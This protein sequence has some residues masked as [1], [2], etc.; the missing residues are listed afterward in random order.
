MER[1][2]EIPGAKKAPIGVPTI[3]FHK[4]DG[5]NLRWEWS[6]KKGW[7]KFG[8][9]TELFDWRH[10]MWGQAIP[11]FEKIKDEIV[12]RVKATEWKNKG[13]QRITAFTEFFGPSSF[14]GVHVEDEPK[15]LKL[16]DVYL[17]KRGMMPPKQFVETFG[18]L[19]YAAQAVYKGNLNHQFI[20]DVH[21]GLYPVNEGVVAKGD[22]YRVK[23]KTYA[24][25]KKLN[26]VFGA[27][28]KDYWE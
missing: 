1:Y 11:L 14:A 4:Y 24:Y 8:T 12:E 28:F 20:E 17:F 13:I 10:P 26:E 15:E 25:L 22:D 6:P 7:H 16:F 27:K 9:R 19:P 3:A 18:D 2:P 5:S 23:I 21:M